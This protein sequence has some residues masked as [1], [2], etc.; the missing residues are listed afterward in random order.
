MLT[1]TDP[2]LEQWRHTLRDGMASPRLPLPPNTAGM[3]PL[4]TRLA[5]SVTAASPALLP[6]SSD[7]S[8]C[9]ESFPSCWLP[10]S[11]PPSSSLPSSP[12]FIG[13]RAALSTS[14][15]FSDG[16]TAKPPPRSALFF[17]LPVG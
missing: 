12:S 3:R 11:A 9:V 13:D 6:T 4:G 7:V 14:S 17:A 1:A 16:M 8:A 15:W 5:T 10:V 2:S